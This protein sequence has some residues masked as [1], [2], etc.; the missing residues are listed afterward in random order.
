[1]REYER[2]TPLTN[3][4]VNLVK[5]GENNISNRDYYLSER[6]YRGGYDGRG[7][8][9]MHERMQNVSEPHETEK[10]KMNKKVEQLFNRYRN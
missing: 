10:S 3:A 2:N 4:Y 5:K 8:M 6:T 9:P 7:Q 1:M